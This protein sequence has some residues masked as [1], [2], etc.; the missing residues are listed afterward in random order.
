M[1]RNAYNEGCKAAM[2]RFKI[3]GGIP[4]APASAAPGIAASPR[5]SAGAAPSAVPASPFAPGGPPGA[6]TLGKGV[7]KLPTL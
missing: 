7:D 2:M 3:A 5:L 4:G 1:L 6:P